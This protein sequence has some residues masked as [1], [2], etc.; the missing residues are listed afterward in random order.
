MQTRSRTVPVSPV[1]VWDIWVRLFHWGLVLCMVTAALTGFLAD[2]RWA[3]V[4]VAAGL[5]A[6]G[7]VLARIVWGVLGTPH[8][9]F[10]DFLP[11]PAA[12]LAHIRGTGPRHRG[13]NPLGALMVLALI[14]AVLALT[15]SGLV[16]LGGWFRLGPLAAGLDPDAGQAARALH[17]VVAFAVL[18]L[19][20]LH[21]GGVAV[22][23]RRDGENLARSMVTGRKQ[24]RPGDARPI[25][26]RPQGA[27]AL[28]VIAGLAA[29]LT[30]GALA[31][32]ARPADNL[33]V[34]QIDPLTAEECGACHMVYHPSLL[35]AASWRQVMTGLDSHF[36]ENAW[37]A[38]A[39]AA[40]IEAW[41]TANA[42]ETVATGPATL[43]S[44]TD[45]AAP[46]ALTETPAWRRIH[47]DLPDALFERAPV[48]SRG[49]C[50]ACHA[51]AETGLFNPF[52]IK[53]PKET[54]E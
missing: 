42:A 25:E 16:I 7:L 31:L 50:A 3:A 26:G 15:V 19:V 41:L 43:F 10:A 54:T 24:A 28:K 1:P 32:W 35:P 33:P 13:H 4:H 6:A 34:R 36:G 53:L 52:A 40:E 46:G 51:D 11:R 38:P 27:S 23:S 21:V 47:H 22:E 5:A 20:A 44:R 30:L 18:A 45:P 37:I 2:A 39:D 12:L 17:E 14:A 8:A 9:R 49:N 29:V 48:L